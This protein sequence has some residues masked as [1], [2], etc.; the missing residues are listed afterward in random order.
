MLLTTGV[1]AGT[2]AWAAWHG[3]S[4]YFY[5]MLLTNAHMLNGIAVEGSILGL[6]ILFLHRRGW[7]PSDL[8][9]RPSMRGTIEGLVL[10]IGLYL[11]N[12][13]TFVLIFLLTFFLRGSVGVAA[14]AASLKPELHPHTVHIAW[15]AI[16]LGSVINALLEEIA[17][18]AY[19][20]CQ[21]AARHGPLA[22]LLLTDLLRMGYHTYQGPLHMLGVGAVF[23]V[24]DGYYAVRKNLWAVVIAHA[25]SDIISFAVLKQ[26]LG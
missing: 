10:P 4:H 8:R 15:S 21:V 12:F 17:C 22:A 13:G 19:F 9:L 7:I 23:L 16:I 14:L 26:I 2:S 25:G 5:E 20:F 11:A 18:T 6:L 1:F 24:L 3:S